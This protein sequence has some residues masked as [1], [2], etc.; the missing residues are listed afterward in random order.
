MSS[1]IKVA[2]TG[3]SGHLGMSL[4][5]LLL[6]QGF[7][8]KAL[9]HSFLPPTKNDN[10]TWVKGDI[11][12]SKSAKLLLDECT[13]VVH[14][15]SV[16]SVEDQFEKRVFDT[17]INGTQNIIEACLAENITRLIHIS[18]SHA[19][20]E[21]KHNEIFDESRPYKTQND[22]TYPWSKAK[23][24]QLVIN[25]IGNGLNAIILRPTSIVGPPDSRPSLMG[26]ILFDMANGKIPAIT[27][28]GYDIVDV[29]DLSQTIINSFSNGRSGEIY[30]TG[31]AFVPVNKLA[32]FSNPERKPIKVSLD[33]LLFIYPF[34]KI[35]KRFF[36]IP[37]PITKQSLLALK[38]APKRVDS[39][40]A[41]KELNHTCRPIEETIENLLTWNKKEE[42]NE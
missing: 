30:N 4:I 31:G 19:V 9:Y 37:W 14:C 42:E 20:L 7:L 13:H 15:A 17:N 16:V 41:K 25:A 33:I 32:Q 35:Y 18:S 28:G 21:P 23:A 12:T 3:G 1:P 11:K 38:N 6:K 24:E 26:K 2:V 22:Y 36:K 34:I 5:E 27:S 8:V 40:K 10:L 29:R 39:S